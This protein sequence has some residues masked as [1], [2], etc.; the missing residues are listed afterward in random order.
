MKKVIIYSVV[1]LCAF[2]FCEGL[3][4]QNVGIGVATPAR[5]LDING[6]LRIRVLVAPPASFTTNDVVMIRLNNGD[7]TGTK[8]TGNINDVFRG[9]G[10]FGPSPG[11]DHDW[12][13]V[14]TTNPPNNINDNIYT[15]GRVGI[16]INVPTQRLHVVGN[17]RL[18]GDFR[19]NNNPGTAGQV[20]ISQGI[21]TPP[22]WQTPTWAK[23][24][25]TALATYVQKWTGTELCNTIIRD[26]GSAVGINAAPTTLDITYVYRPSTNTGAGKSTLR[27]YR[28]GTFGAT[29]GGSNW[30]YSGV[31]VAIKAV[32]FW[33]NEYSAALGAHSYTTYNNSAVAVFEDRTIASNDTWIGYRDVNGTRWGVWSTGTG[34]FMK[35][36]FVEDPTMTNGGIPAADINKYRFVVQ[37]PGRPFMLV[38]DEP[39]TVVRIGRSSGVLYQDNTYKCL[40]G[41]K[42]Y[43]NYFVDV[44]GGDVSGQVLGV[45]SVEYLVDGIDHL[46]V[47]AR[48]S[49]VRSSAATC[50]SAPQPVIDLGSTNNRWRYIYLQNSPNVAS[51][52]R[53]KKNIQDLTYGLET[54]LQLRPVTYQWKDEIHDLPDDRVMIGFVAQELMKVIPEVV[55]THHYEWTDETKTRYVKKANATYG[56][57]YSELIPV[58]VNAIKELNQKLEEANKR[59]E[60]LENQMK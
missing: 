46:F 51:D 10:T 22:V 40:N 2:L 38:V 6:D 3:F 49:P 21:N 53:L 31:D 15:Q 45:G 33:G 20:L 13:E 12:Y 57:H 27:A 58:L 17:F 34:R 55:P 52:A 43:I 36:L 11:I 54:V 28:N 29:N 48:F 24:C 50:S 25:N 37:T 19:P 30:K 18:Q 59:I 1:F 9:D 47:S 7:V 44:D 5:K 41:S 60:Y 4:A 14:G 26:N 39:D 8:L 16:G 32:N 35:R 56:V 42:T 23:I